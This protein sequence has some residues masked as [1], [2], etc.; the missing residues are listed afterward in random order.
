M[1]ARR[2]STVRAAPCFRADFPGATAIP[3]TMLASRSKLESTKNICCR[4]TNVLPCSMR[5][6]L[7]GSRSA[8][9]TR[10]TLGQAPSK[11]ERPSSKRWNEALAIPV[12]RNKGLFA[13]IPESWPSGTQKV[14]Q[15]AEAGRKACEFVCSSD[16][17]RATTAAKRKHQKQKQ[18]RK[19]AQTKVLATTNRT[20]CRRRP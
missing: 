12:A 7:S 11:A 14:R 17:V 18:Q 2:I 19:A 8:W 6:L 15:D 3:P 13:I 16:A 9:N 4:V 20:G 10:P 1:R 5:K